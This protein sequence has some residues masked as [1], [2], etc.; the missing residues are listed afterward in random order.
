[1]AQSRLTARLPT[2]ARTVSVLFFSVSRVFPEESSRIITSSSHYCFI[3][4]FIV[5][6][7]QYIQPINHKTTSSY[8]KWLLLWQCSDGVASAIEASTAILCLSTSIPPVCLRP[9]GLWGKSQLRIRVCGVYVCLGVQDRA[10]FPAKFPVT[11]YKYFQKH[12]GSSLCKWTKQT[13]FDAKRDVVFANCVLAF[14]S[15]CAKFPAS[16]WKGTLR[17]QVNFCVLFWIILKCVFCFSGFV[18]WEEQLWP[19]GTPLVSHPL[20]GLFEKWF[21]LLCR[22]SPPTLFW[23][24]LHRIYLAIRPCRLHLFSVGLIRPCE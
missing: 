16:W 15:R 19:C 18:S 11:Y 10:C 12:F 9:R 3:F 5:R 17:N 22:V 8:S 6:V 1:M 24:K 23:I 2:P 20:A 14:R 13:T 7:I 21:S 4:G